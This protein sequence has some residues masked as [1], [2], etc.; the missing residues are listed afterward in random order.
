MPNKIAQSNNLNNF[1]IFRDNN[2]RLE[3]IIKKY[4]NILDYISEYYR[5]I[6]SSARIFK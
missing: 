6:K 1:G 2:V 4:E 3:N 5:K